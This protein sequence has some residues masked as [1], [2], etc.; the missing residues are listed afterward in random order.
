MLV[1][2][3][4]LSVGVAIGYW[5]ASH[6]AD[7]RLHTTLFAVGCQRI[8]VTANV[9]HQLPANTPTRT[10]RVLE[11]EL[12][13]AVA[14]T[15]RNITKAQGPIYE[16][17][18]SSVTTDALAKAK[19]FAVQNKDDDLLKGIEFLTHQIGSRG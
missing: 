2:L 6:R 9:I 18:S 13:Q 4:T 1:F 8:I 3:F 16:V 5:F 10:R 7:R 12:R 14:D 15:S 19:T 11:L 17:L